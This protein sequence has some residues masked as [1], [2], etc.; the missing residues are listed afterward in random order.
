MSTGEEPRADREWAHWPARRTQDERIRDRLRSL[1]QATDEENAVE[2]LLTDEERSLDDRVRD[3]ADTIAELERREARTVDL[4]NAVE[5]MLRRG[6]AELDERHAELTAL[7]RELAEREDALATAEHE[8]SDRRQELGAVELRRAALERREDALRER[9]ATI[10]QLQ[11]AID[12]REH[13]LASA[14]DQVR[15]Q[16]LD[17]RERTL[18]EREAMVQALVEANEQREQEL[19]ERLAALAAEPDTVSGAAPEAAEETAHLLFL[20]GH[21]YRLQEARGPAPGV[22]ALVELD[23]ATYRVTRVAGSPLPGDRRRC[24]YLELLDA[25]GA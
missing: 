22:L 20:P 16:S 19:R 18:E 21:R 17:D 14:E 6:S 5:D 24:A 25:A 1:F 10:E 7:A 4:R 3:V 9:E 8:L 12:V 23:Q 11:S 15:E 2:A 13:D